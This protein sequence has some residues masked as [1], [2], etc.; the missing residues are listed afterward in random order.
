MTKEERATAYAKMLYTPGSYAADVA[1]D[2]FI[3]GVNWGDD[4]SKL[5]LDE[6][7][8]LIERIEGAKLVGWIP[9]T[10]DTKKAQQLIKDAGREWEK[11]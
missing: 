11:P 5:I 3:E 8:H 4:K 9:P 6:L 10:F 7:I 1:T 2:A